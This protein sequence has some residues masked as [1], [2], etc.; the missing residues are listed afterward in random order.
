MRD[1]LIAYAQADERITAAAL[2]GSAVRGAEDA[3]SDIDLMLRLADGQPPE[4]MADD[5][6]A[7]MR[8]AHGAVAHTD[9]RAGPALYRVFLLGNSLQVDV[10][11][12]PSADFA[13][14]GPPIQLAFGEANEPRPAASRDLDALVG[15]AWLYALHVRSSIARGRSLQALYMINTVRDQVITL[16]C[17]RHGLPAAHARG[18][19]EL[20]ED[21]ERTIASTLVRELSEDELR[22]A[23]AV[24]VDALLL[25][26]THVDPTQAGLL[27][28][29]LREMVRTAQRP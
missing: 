12:W 24:L 14:T 8:V 17:V 3:W 10:S 4:D 19:D 27:A 20:P 25:E 13:S 7:R 18:A 16:A 21:V 15:T 1:D 28:E 29:P 23:F 26:A 2:V 11:F 6:T 5:W 9:V 22:R